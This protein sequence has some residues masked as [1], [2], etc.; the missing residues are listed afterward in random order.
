M[1]PSAH[2]EVVVLQ[3]GNSSYRKLHTTRSVDYFGKPWFLDRDVAVCRVH[4]S[5]MIFKRGNSLNLF[6]AVLMDNKHCSWG[7]REDILIRGWSLCLNFSCLLFDTAECPQ[8]A[9]TYLVSL[10]EH[11]GPFDLHV[12]C[13]W[14]GNSSS[15]YWS[16]CQQCEMAQT[17][18]RS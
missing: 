16:P 2:L 4:S 10:L 8:Y 17:Q 6:K 18:Q 13:A 15:L 3:R 7:K 12:F 14:E 11:P 9:V 5:F 1:L